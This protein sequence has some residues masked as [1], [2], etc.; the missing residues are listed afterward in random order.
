MAVMDTGQLWVTWMKWMWRAQRFH[1]LPPTSSLFR[2]PPRWCSEEPRPCSL[3][4]RWAERR[5][6]R[7]YFEV[8]EWQR[9][10]QQEL[11]RTWGQRH[12]P[13]LALRNV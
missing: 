9:L 1:A 5:L 4:E 6:K 8:M 12:A 7:M 13:H 3:L 2:Y 11:D 10:R